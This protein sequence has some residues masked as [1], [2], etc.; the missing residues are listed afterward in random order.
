LLN[1]KLIY[2]TNERFVNQT[3]FQYRSQFKLLFTLNYCNG[4]VTNHIENL[5]S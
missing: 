1:N 5:F 3:A 4:G 2:N